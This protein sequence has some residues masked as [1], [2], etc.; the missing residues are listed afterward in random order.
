MNEKKTVGQLFPPTPLLVSYG[1]VHK[2]CHAPGGKG[3]WESVT[4]CDKGRGGKD[5]VTSQFLFFHNSQFNVLFDIFSYI[6]QIEV[7]NITFRV[8]KK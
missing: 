2:V 5:H 3:V 1:A 4:A 7:A 8:V 6:V